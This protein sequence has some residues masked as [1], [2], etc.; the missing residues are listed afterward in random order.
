MCFAPQQRALFQHVVFLSFWLGNVLRA[1]T[2]C[3]FSSSLPKAV[4]TG[5]A[6]TF[7]TSTC[8]WRH[9]SV[10]F[11]IS[12]LARWLRTRRFREPTFRPSRATNHQKKTH[13]IAPFLPFGAPVSSVFALFLFSDL[14]TSF[15]LL[16]DSFHLWFFICSYCRKFD[17]KTSF[18]YLSI[19]MLIL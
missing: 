17:F 10:P 5:V 9:N 11:F 12:H 6:F 19:L 18:E 7:F 2:A 4:R 8:A 14:L 15:L 16:S 3:T 13:W 1:T